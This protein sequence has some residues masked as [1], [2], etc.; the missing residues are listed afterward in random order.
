MAKNSKDI[1]QNGLF[2]LTDKFMH[3]TDRN[4]LS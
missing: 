1:A 4:T 2:E 3:I